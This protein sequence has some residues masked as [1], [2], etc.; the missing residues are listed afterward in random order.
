MFSIFFF[1]FQAEDGIRDVAVTGVQTCAL[2]ISQRGG[3]ARADRRRN[4]GKQNN[5]PEREH[6]EREQV[7]HRS[8]LALS[9][10]GISHCPSGLA[11]TVPREQRRMRSFRSVAAAKKAAVAVN[12]RRVGRLHGR[13][14]TAKSM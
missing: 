10:R 7:G 13:S 11:S 6:R 5:V 8:M 2:P 14:R 3:P 1:F 4:T 12:S 9:L